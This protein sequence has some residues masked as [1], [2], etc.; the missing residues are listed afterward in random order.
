MASSSSTKK[1]AQGGGRT[2]NSEP[3]VQVFRDFAGCNFQLS[4][5]EFTLG[6]EAEEQSDLQMNYVVI[7]NNAEISDNKTIET[8]NA[9]K[10]LK[11]APQNTEFSGVSLLVRD[12]LFMATDDGRIIFGACNDSPSWHTLDIQTKTNNAHHFTSLIYVDDKIVGLTKENEMYI[13]PKL[14]W[15]Y[16]NGFSFPKLE[17][18][19]NA[20]IANSAGLDNPAALAFSNL[21]ARG[22]LKIMD[23]YDSDKEECVYRVAVAY[24]K[25]NQFG[26]TEVS[27]QFTFYANYPVSEWHSGCYLQIK[28]TVPANTDIKAVEI[29]Y[30]EGNASSLQFAGRVDFTGTSWTFDWFGYLDAT[31]MWS[32]ANLLSPEDNYTKGVPAS[33]MICIDSRIYFWGD[34]D[35]PQRLYIG[36]NPGN[37]YSTSPGTGGGFV[38]IEPGSGQEIRVVDKYKTQSGNSI[39]T[40][41]CDSPNSTQER[42]YNLV[43]NT[44][45]ISNEQNMKSW[46]AEQVSG[47]VGCKSQR[48]AIVAEDG[49]YAV[50]RYG[51]ALTTMTM[52]YNSQIRA[53]YVSGPIKPVFTGLSG[54]QL[55]NAI[56][57][58]DDAVLYLA[59]GDTSNDNIDNMVFCYDIDLKSWWT[60]TIDVPNP[61]INL[62]HI[63]ADNEQEGIGII[64]KNA[65]YLLPSTEYDEDDCVDVLIQT[66]ELSTQQ[67]QQ[68]WFYLSQL[69]FRFDYFIGEIII[70]I[71]AIDQFGRNIR[72]S[73][74]IKE[75]NIVYDLTDWMRVDLR[76]K[77]YRIRIHGNASF[78]MT[79][80]MA[81]V[82]VMSAK[83]GIVWGFD[84]SQSYREYG[85]IH[86]T[87]KDYNDIKK[88]II[89]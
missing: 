64:T 72:T 83:Q 21:T 35:N 70:D 62:I 78:R 7:Q 26:P 37:L 8:R 17:D 51:L 82:Y 47:A 89:V 41:L 30:N 80:F 22:S 55:S 44:I 86:P 53:N 45:T 50:S 61:I 15:V 71:D 73:K 79:H 28:R 63:D 84:D 68:N 12:C 59:F 40:M 11:A 33:Y 2:A 14:N 49:L 57:L 58:E 34:K 19:S 25:V 27:R 69:E 52:E 66:G 3:R 20:Y 60:I 10:K 36:G 76:L 24:S 31:S 29:Y 65:T 32:V 9:I 48:G 5:R 67:P 81:K 85:D 87:F 77:S 23:H 18:G 46:Q 1:R 13:T 43:E 56:L 38:D 42:R 54:N 6:H 39:V 88:A 74:M 16:Q 4:P 75:D